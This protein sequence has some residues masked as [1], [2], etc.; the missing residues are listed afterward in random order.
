MIIPE[1]HELAGQNL[2]KGSE[3]GSCYSLEKTIDMAIDDW[4]NEYKL[5]TMKDVRECN[6]S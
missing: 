4:I 2:W 1:N 5:A 6:S 3:T